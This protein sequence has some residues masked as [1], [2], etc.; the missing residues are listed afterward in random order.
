[1][2]LLVGLGMGARSSNILTKNSIYAPQSDPLPY[3]SSSVSP[4]ENITM[5]KANSVTFLLGVLKCRN[6]F[7]EG[8]KFASQ[9]PYSLKVEHQVDLWSAM[10]KM[11]K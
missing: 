4:L 7:I 5:E 9:N 2:F 10:K 6:F 3:F 11:S 8:R 1:M